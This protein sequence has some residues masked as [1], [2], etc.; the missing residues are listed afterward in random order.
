MEGDEWES[1]EWKEV[2]EGG[3][4]RGWMDG[5]EW[6]GVRDSGVIVVG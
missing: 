3:I 2:N 6:A 5:G 4:F 1:G